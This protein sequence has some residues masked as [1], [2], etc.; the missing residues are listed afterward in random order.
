MVGRDARDLLSRLSTNDLKP[1]DAGRAVTTLFLSPTGRLLHRVLLQ[2]DGTS[3][4]AVVESGVAQSFASWVDQYT[5]AED[6]RVEGAPDLGV[7]EVHGD[8]SLAA[9][10][11]HETRGALAWSRRDFGPFACA[12]VTGPREELAALASDLPSLGESERL[13]LRVLAGVPA[14]PSEI[15]EDYFPLEAGLVGEISFT[16]GCYTGQEVV[17]RQDSRDKVVR[18]LVGLAFDADAAV[19]PGDVLASEEKEGCRVTSVA[20]ELVEQ[21]GARRR[22]ALGYVRSRSAPGARVSAAGG[23]EATVVALPFR[24]PS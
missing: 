8:V 5:F 17:A 23:P 11:D 20:P 15:C 1:L 14:A 24:T 4:R 12:V 18:R 9:T 13:Q 22:V 3:L 19:A 2:P 21:E 7:L 16:K 10:A 6:A